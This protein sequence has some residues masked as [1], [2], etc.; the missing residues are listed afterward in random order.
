[1]VFLSLPQSTRQ[2]CISWPTMEVRLTLTT[3][4][5]IGSHGF[6][7]VSCYSHRG[8]QA[9][10]GR[11]WQ[12]MDFRVFYAVVIEVTRKTMA[13]MV[14]KVENGRKWQKK[15]SPRLFGRKWISAYF[16]PF[17]YYLQSITTPFSRAFMRY[18]Q[19]LIRGVF[20]FLPLLGYYVFLI[21]ISY[22]KATLFIFNPFFF[23]TASPS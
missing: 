11:K 8:D 7:R 19:H 17:P 12:E 5:E 18:C 16:T 2:P 1:M 10:N 6:P 21:V 22:H 23:Q 14:K 4:A 9:G 15:S 13:K 3:F 20:L